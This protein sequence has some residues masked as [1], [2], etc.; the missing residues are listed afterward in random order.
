VANWRSYG[1]VEHDGLRYGQKAHSWRGL[2]PLP[3]L[4]EEPFAVA[5]AIHPG[6]DADRRD[7]ESAGWTLL[8]PARVA[9]TPARYRDFVRR[10]K[11]EL[12]VA[13]SGYV[14]AAT[15]WFSDRSACYLAAGRPVVAQDTG[16]SSSIPTGAGLLP[17]GD[18]GE[19]AEAVARVGRD[20]E[21]HRRAAMEVARDMFD[22][23]RVLP[24]LLRTVGVVP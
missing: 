12:C 18:L 15:G 6:D 16:F 21:T 20:Y 8:D 7:L 1:T 23:D 19:A 3:G 14:D 5:L 4:V 24:E 11:A 2:L 22:A 17:F 10:S 13:K 9:S